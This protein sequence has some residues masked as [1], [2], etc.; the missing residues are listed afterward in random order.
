MIVGDQFVG[1]LPHLRGQAGAV[2]LAHHEAVVGRGDD[3]AALLGGDLEDAQRALFVDG[4]DLPGAA[5]MGHDLVA[6]DD[7]AQTLPIT[8]RHQDQGVDV[9]RLGVTGRAVQNEAFIAR[10]FLDPLQRVGQVDMPRRLRRLV[11]VGV[12]AEGVELVLGKRAQL[13]QMVGA[14]TLRH[15]GQSFNLARTVGGVGEAEHRGLS[16]GGKHDAARG[17][18]L[19]FG[20]EGVETTDGGA[21]AG[22]L[23]VCV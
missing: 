13:A 2:A 15:R 20:S 18:D 7:V 22:A 3:L 11:R 6:D 14:Q 16:I 17:G 10:L 1:D 5:Q 4:A 8:S 12:F 23:L 19:G 21:G 9:E